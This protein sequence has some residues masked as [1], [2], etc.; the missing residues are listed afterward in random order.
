MPLALAH[1]RQFIASTLLPGQPVDGDEDEELH[2]EK[3]DEDPIPY[4][5]S[6]NPAQISPKLVAWGSFE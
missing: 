6:T 1:A 3:H 2:V 4:L 5:T